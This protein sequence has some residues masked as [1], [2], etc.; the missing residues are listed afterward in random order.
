MNKTVEKYLL[1]LDEEKRKNVHV[2]RFAF[3]YEE[4]MQ[5]NLAALVLKGEKKATTSL[6]AL[7][8]LENERVPQ[9]GDIN[10]ILDS[11]ENEICVTVNT[12]VYRIPFKD[13]SEE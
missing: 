11:Q 3:G 12:K 5:D 7:Y 2:N 10:I 1:T 8:D 4:N 9:K 13:V 6:Y